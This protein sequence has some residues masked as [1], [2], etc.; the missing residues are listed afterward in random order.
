MQ[1]DIIPFNESLT[2]FGFKPS[3]INA[4]NLR[5]HTHIIPQLEAIQVEAKVSDDCERLYISEFD[6]FVD[7]QKKYYHI[8]VIN[9]TDKFIEFEWVWSGAK[10]LMPLTRF[11]A[12][13]KIEEELASNSR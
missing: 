9:R 4:I 10:Q 8:K 1:I 3:E 12:I 11:N 6:Y 13:Y 2:E 7:G 5:I